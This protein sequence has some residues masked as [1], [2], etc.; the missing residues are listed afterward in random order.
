[1]TS[2][3]D[4]VMRLLFVEDEPESVESAIRRLTR[5]GGTHECRVTSFSEAE[6]EID[7]FAPDIVILD[8]LEGGSSAEPKT[9]GQ[10]TYDLIWK[11]KFCPIVVYSARPDALDREGHPFVKSVQ[12]GSDSI[13]QLEEAIGE[14]EPHVNALRAAELHIRREF[15]LALREVAQHAFEVF[16]APDERNNAI[17]RSGRRRLAALT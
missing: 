6:T 1:M 16:T 3:K 7:K 12:K 2:Q 11:R 10:Q 17:I 14:L 4:P 5:D 15:A 9:T 13:V 8:L